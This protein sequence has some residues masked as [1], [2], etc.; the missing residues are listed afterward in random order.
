MYELSNFSSFG[1]LAWE[2]LVTVDFYRR[3]RIIP[4]AKQILKLPVL[5]LH[6]IIVLQTLMAKMSE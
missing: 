1:L 3:I 6:N 4:T 5:T 2:A